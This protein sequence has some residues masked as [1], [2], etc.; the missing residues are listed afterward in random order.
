MYV[1]DICFPVTGGLQQLPRREPEEELAVDGQDELERGEELELELMREET[2][3]FLLD[4]TPTPTIVVFF[5]LFA[6]PTL[7]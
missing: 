1:G 5:F 6:W 2:D 7:G 3:A 4:P